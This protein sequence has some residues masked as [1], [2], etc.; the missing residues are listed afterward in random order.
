MTAKDWKILKDYVEMHDLKPQLST[1]S[2][3]QFRFMDRLGR[4][5][6]VSMTTMKH[7]IEAARKQDKQS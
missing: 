2:I 3:G 4:E 6:K 5:V 7:T 1:P